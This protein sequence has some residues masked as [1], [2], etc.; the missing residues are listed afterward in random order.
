MVVVIQVL[1]LSYLLGA[2][3]VNALTGRRL[4]FFEGMD[5]GGG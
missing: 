3:A 5:L 2:R 4:P 1:V